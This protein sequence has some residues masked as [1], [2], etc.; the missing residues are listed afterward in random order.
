MSPARTVDFLPRKVASI[1]PSRQDKSFLEVMSMR[2]RSATR[3]NVHINDAEAPIGLLARH[4]DGLSIADQTDVRE[5][6]GLRQREI[7]FEAVRRNRWQSSG[8]SFLLWSVRLIVI[9]L[10]PLA[11][12]ACPQ[13]SS[14]F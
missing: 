3:G 5:V 8:H 12:S 1:S 11:P 13:E 9:R 7:A 10:K 6:V 4:R 2:R 14:Q